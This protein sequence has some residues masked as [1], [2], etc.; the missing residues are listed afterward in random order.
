MFHTGDQFENRARAERHYELRRLRHALSDL[1]FGRTVET[2][3][4]M[5]N[6][7]TSA[8]DKDFPT[9]RAA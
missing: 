8:N 4:K 5:P 6:R 2:A 9:S 3:A 7:L 1:L